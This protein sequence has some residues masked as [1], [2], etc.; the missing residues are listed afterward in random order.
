MNFKEPRAF[1]MLLIGL[2]SLP[3][4]IWGISEPN[5]WYLTVGGIGSVITTTAI[6][7]DRTAPHGRGRT[8]RSRTRRRLAWVLVAPVRDCGCFKSEGADT[9]ETDT[10]VARTMDGGRVRFEARSHR[11]RRCHNCGRHYH[12]TANSRTAHVGD[13][14]R[15]K[16][17]DTTGS[18]GI[19]RETV[20]W[21]EDEPEVYDAVEVEIEDTP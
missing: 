5:W 9:V 15:L 4:T 1:L 3:L 19:H 13:E 8:L 18:L 20:V 17:L 6:A 14:S 21:P 7:L 12:D 16:Q 2:Y 11:L 10:F